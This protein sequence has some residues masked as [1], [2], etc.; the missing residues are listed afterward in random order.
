MNKTENNICDFHAHI[1]P[2]AD[3]GSSS[4][5]TSIRQLTLAQNCGVCRIVASPHFYA[6]KESVDSFLKRR[7]DSFELLK[8]NIPD[9]IEVVC[10]AEVLLCDNMEG[11]PGID[12]LTVGDSNVILIELPLFDFKDSYYVTVAELIARGLKVVLVP[13]HRY[14]TEVIDEL[15]ALGATLQLNCESIS[16]LFSKNAAA[17]GWLRRGIVSA[18]GSDIHGSDKNAYRNFSLA[19]KRNSPYIA[20]IKEKS[21][22]LWSLFKAE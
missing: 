1:L 2:G 11:L 16:G 7:D 17:V 8:P 10:G 4:I 18:I 15:V 6:H 3:H 5:E 21:D 20:E 14:D 22:C 19:I 12:S 13:P 9:G